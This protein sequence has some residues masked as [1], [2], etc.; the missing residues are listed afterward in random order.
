MLGSKAILN[1]YKKVEITKQHIAQ[2]SVGYRR[3]KRGNQKFPLR[4]R[5]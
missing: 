1:K 3:N 2:G 5:E 4:E